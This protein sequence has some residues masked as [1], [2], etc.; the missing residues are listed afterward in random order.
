[1]LC[2]SDRFNSLF[3]LVTTIS[4]Y[5]SLLVH[6]S[7]KV[8]ENKEMLIKFATQCG[9]GVKSAYTHVRVN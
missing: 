1:M 4:K 9:R 7:M 3:S 5:L 6:Y 8:I 2:R